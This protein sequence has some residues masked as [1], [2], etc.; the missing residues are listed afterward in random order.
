M[1]QDS[2]HHTDRGAPGEA[3]DVDGATAVKIRVGSGLEQQLEALEV[4][5][6]SADVQRADHQGSERARGG[7]GD[8]R[9]QVVVDVH[10]SAIPYQLSQDV[11]PAHAGG[12]VHRGAAMVMAPVGVCASFQQDLGALQVPVHHSHVEGCLPLH[13]HQIN[14]RPFL[15]EEIHAVAMASGGSD[16]QRGAGQPAT[17][18]HRL[19]VD[20]ALE[21]LL[22]QQAPECVQVPN[23]G[24]IMQPR[25]FAVLE[26][27]V[28][29]LLPQP[30][31]QIATCAAFPSVAP[32]V[33]P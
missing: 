5:I 3:L 23:I 18:P 20:S 28:A 9:G 6:G 15:E 31:L 10:V 13:I 16:A 27:V 24:S 1:S 7:A 14:L 8:P 33:A 32:R 12:V 19:L 21:A 2:I 22:L 17:A 11:G 29:E 4:V 25:V 30:L 26:G